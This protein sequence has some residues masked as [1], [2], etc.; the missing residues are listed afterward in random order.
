MIQAY[1]MFML[2]LSCALLCLAATPLLCA[3]TMQTGFGFVTSISGSVQAQ[4]KD[5][6]ARNFSLH[7]NQALD[8]IK[9]ESGPEDSLILVLSNGVA[10]AITENTQVE[11]NTFKQIPFDPDSNTIQYE[12]T[13]SDLQIHLIQGTVALSCDHIS[14][15]SNLK[16][17][18]QDGHLRVHSTTSVLSVN[19]IGM[20]VSAYQGTLTYHYPNGTEREFIAN[21]QSIRISQQSAI[22]GI[23]TESTNVDTQAHRHQNLAAAVDFARSRV[24]YRS[25]PD[26]TFP[27]PHLLVPENYL[28]QKPVRPYS[29]K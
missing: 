3:Q 6:Q 25:V 27:Q 8:G 1:R 17:K 10:L 18:M 5:G 24:I 12:P 23:V 22:R 9:I 20:Q 2:R 29:F 26:E 4:S 14:P 28:A 15:L 19:P 11:F 13:V 16:I 7:Q 21:P